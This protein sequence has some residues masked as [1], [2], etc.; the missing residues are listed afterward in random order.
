[1]MVSHLLCILTPFIWLPPIVHP[2]D[3]F[4]PLLSR[5][6]KQLHRN[7]HTSPLSGLLICNHCLI[8]TSTWAPVVNAKR[9]PSMLWAS[10]L[11]HRGNAHTQ[12]LIPC[13][14]HPRP[15][16][17]LPSKSKPRYRTWADHF[18]MAFVNGTRHIMLC[19]HNHERWSGAF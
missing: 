19:V 15:W 12:N 11:R 10:E 5:K 1:M 7:I 18:P 9:W 3:D 13:C 17:A 6:W 16:D 14:G 8:P 4:V 2:T